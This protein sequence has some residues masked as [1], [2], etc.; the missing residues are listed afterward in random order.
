MVVDTAVTESTK[1]TCMGQVGF[2]M[3]TIIL[4]G[5][6]IVPLD[7]AVWGLEEGKDGRIF[8]LAVYPWPVR[9]FL[10]LKMKTINS[11]TMA[12]TSTSTVTSLVFL[13]DASAGV[14][15]GTTVFDGDGVTVSVGGMVPV[16][17][18]AVSTGSWVAADEVPTRR[19]GVNVVAGRTS[20]LCP[21]WITVE[22][23]GMPFRR[24]I[25]STLTP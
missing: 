12:M 6:D 17:G 22:S 7:T 1:P 15:V 9:G 2:V 16:G 8:I 4:K 20:N 23:P 24:R 13:D 21:T 25:S 19:A 18:M 10:K 5:H 14:L 11:T 3:G